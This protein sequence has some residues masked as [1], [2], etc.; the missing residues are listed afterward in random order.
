VVE[1]RSG[2]PGLKRCKRTALGPSTPERVIGLCGMGDTL[3]ASG[4]SEVTFPSYCIWCFSI[5]AS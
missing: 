5:L 3:R 1:V 4:N 2:D